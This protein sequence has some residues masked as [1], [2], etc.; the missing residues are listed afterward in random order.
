MMKKKPK[1]ITAFCLAIGIALPLSISLAM[2]TGAHLPA[3]APVPN[4]DSSVKDT[5]FR[6]LHLSP[7][8]VYAVD[9][10]GTEWEYD[11]SHNIFIKHGKG[12]QQTETIFRRQ[13]NGS[14][15]LSD[16]LKANLYSTIKKVKGLQLG[17]IEIGPDEKVDG[18]LMAVGPIIIQGLVNG[19]VT[20]YKKITVTSTGEITG[21]A[22]APEIAKMRG[23]IIRGRRHETSLP[24]MAE[25]HL[26][27]KIS[28]GGL[29]V[30]AIIL[31][32]LIFCGFLAVA[33]IPKPTFRIKY[34][35]QTRFFRSFF[36]GFISWIL[37]IPLFALLCLTI[38]GIPIAILVMPLGLILGVILG[39]VGLG[40]LVGE[41][42]NQFLGGRFNSQILQAIVGITILYLLWII[43]SLLGLSKSGLYQGLSISF[44]VLAI[45]IWSVGGTAGLGAVIL[46]RFGSRSYDKIKNL[47]FEAGALPPSPPPPTPPPLKG[48]VG[49]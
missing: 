2:A 23:G 43:V 19:D 17:A 24:Q 35:I 9:S 18:P 39:S 31:T 32:I 49:A 5:V 22:N 44:M 45:I 41:R 33:I 10:D 27:E 11:F 20:S 7:E 42:F 6:D 28:Y 48:G 36:V 16:S 8:G 13:Q 12:N 47:S 21:D 1:Y 38:I 46:T 3:K 30:N 4:R 37:L 15:Y 25:I 14:V 26:F 40:Q 34:C 29:I